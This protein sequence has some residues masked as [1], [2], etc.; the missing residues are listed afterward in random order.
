MKEE[1]CGKYG[2]VYAIIEYD[3]ASIKQI[4]NT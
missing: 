4:K 2:T 1:L 3:T